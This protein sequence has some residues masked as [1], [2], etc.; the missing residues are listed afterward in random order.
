MLLPIY[1][2]S[3]CTCTPHGLNSLL[4]IPPHGVPSTTIIVEFLTETSN[5]ISRVPSHVDSTSGIPIDPSI[6]SDLIKLSK[7]ILRCQL[8]CTLNMERCDIL[9]D[10][11]SIGWGSGVGC[12]PC[13]T[14]WS[15][16]GVCT[17]DDI[18][19]TTFGPAVLDYSPPCGPLSVSSILY[20]TE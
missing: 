5:A 12:I 9:I 3:T 18:D 11:S 10:V 20:T 4:V 2:V 13:V 19:F 8:T 17:F 14:V 1:V 6:T 7:L 15:W 16:K